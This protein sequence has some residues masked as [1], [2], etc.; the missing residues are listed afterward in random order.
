MSTEN[1]NGRLGQ[2]VLQFNRT[3]GTLLLALLCWIANEAW[4]EMKEMRSQI[5]HAVENQA[6]IAG[7]LETH[8]YRLNGHDRR[9][10]R[11]ESSGNP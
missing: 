2:V 8:T 10:E 3:V 9:I 11:L 1:G 7:Q 5:A 4:V 6:K